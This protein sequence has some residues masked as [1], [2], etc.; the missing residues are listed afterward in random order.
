MT[1]RGAAAIAF[2]VLGVYFVA[3]SISGIVV[4]TQ[5]KVQDSSFAHFAHVEWFPY[6]GPV[7]SIVCGIGLLVFRR[8]LAA[9]IAPASKLAD[10]GNGTAGLQAAAI[11]VIGVF[12][13]AGGLQGFIAE[14]LTTQGSGFR[15]T[16]Q[17]A[18]DL[19]VGAALFLG[20]RGIVVVW[21]KLR[22]AGRSKDEPLP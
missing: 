17:S 7:I 2:G 21:Q 10:E 16:A 4:A 20:A 11:A 13:F 18:T 9:L 14:E 5:M 8:V 6:L 1:P 12:I 15:R 19:A 3:S 22:T